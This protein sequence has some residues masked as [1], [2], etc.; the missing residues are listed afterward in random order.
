VALVLD[1][2]T[3][4]ASPQ[5]HVQF[6]PSFHTVQQDKFDFIRQIKVGFVQQALQ[7]KKKSKRQQETMPP[8]IPMNKRKC[9]R[10]EAVPDSKGAKRL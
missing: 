1:Q 4:L 2:V 5:F 9:S 10:D 8:A 3:G 6:D 7:D